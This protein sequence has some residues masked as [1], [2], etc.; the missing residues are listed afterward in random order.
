[1][2]RISRTL[3][4]AV[5]VVL[6]IAL[7]LAYWTFHGP[8]I[9][10]T[11]IRIAGT[12]HQDTTLYMWGMREGLF[13]KKYDI[14]LVVCD[15]TFNEQ[16]EIV[17][18]NGCDIAMATVD[19]LAAKSK[20]L[21]LADRRVLYLMPAWLFEGQIFVSRP[22]LPSLSE[23]RTQFPGEQALKRFFSQIRGKKIAVPEGSSYDQAIRRLM[24]TAG[25]DPSDYSFINA[26]LE[27]GI[28]GL[29]DPN[30]ALAA[31]GIVERPEAERRGYKVALN[32]VDLNAIV[33][34]GF[35]SSAAFY[36]DHRDAVDN[37]LLGWFESV[38]GGLSHPHEN[39]AIFSSYVSG[40]GAK[41]PSFDE[42]ER[43]LR[44]TRFS[45]TPTEVY[46]AFLKPA[47]PT[48]WQKP[49]VERL[50]QLRE[51]GQEDQ[52]TTST[53]DF[54]ADEVVARLMRKYTK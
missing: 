29:S 51:A 27:A 35:I 10:G 44:Y 8:T 26:E 46:D 48:Y 34:A 53:A 54:I 7:A 25:V 41:P 40:R 3:G 21:D 9:G 15:T 19:E 33:I 28:N 39:Y 17:A 50:K 52:A 11:T 1:M 45:R 5:I 47:S 13:R 16:I 49:W 38:D 37:F 36:K 24:T 12:P 4:A 43:A 20:N 32:S 14:N 22:T 6:V 31:A 30:V 42:Y 2:Q 23:L 18:G